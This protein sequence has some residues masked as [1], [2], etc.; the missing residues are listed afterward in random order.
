MPFSV[1]NF[2]QKATENFDETDTEIQIGSADAHVYLLVGG[3]NGSKNQSAEIVRLNKLRAVSYTKE[4][5]INIE[6]DDL[7]VQIANLGF[8]TISD[9]SCS[10]TEC[11]I[12]GGKGKLVS[13]DGKSFTDLSDNIQ[14]N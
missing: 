5:V 1:Y 3:D 12:V 11:L 7:S 4:G 2:I 14:F 8:Q 10:E 9:I 13:Y 6:T